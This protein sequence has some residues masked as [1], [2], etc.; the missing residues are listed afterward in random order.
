MHKRVA[1]LFH[2][3]RALRERD[4]L[5][6]ASTRTARMSDGEFWKL[7]SKI[8][9]GTKTTDYKAIKSAILNKYHFK[10]ELEGIR[11]TFAKLKAALYQQLNNWEAE[12]EEL[13]ENRN[14]GTGDDGFDDLC[15]HIIGLGWKEYN[16]VLKDPKKA[17]DRAQKRDYVESF[18]YALP[19]GDEHDKHKKG[20]YTAWAKR[21]IQDYT[22]VLR[23]SDLKPFHKEAKKLIDILK[24]MAN[25]KPDAFYAKRKEAKKLAQKLYDDWKRVSRRLPR[26]SLVMPTKWSVWNLFS[27]LKEDYFRL[28]SIKLARRW[29]Q[30]QR[31]T[32]A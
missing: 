26:E 16:S 30:E 12:G 1:F 22:G 18:S 24:L 21:T 23:D 5:Y 29:E 2:E 3:K 28:T 32:R 27:D 8:G 14:F 15:S 11:D 31:G 6:V 7:V 13:G 9:W 19:Y 4:R 25:N 20:E 10:K 17:W